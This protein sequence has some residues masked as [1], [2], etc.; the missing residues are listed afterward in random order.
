MNAHLPKLKPNPKM[1][2]NLLKSK[3]KA[4]VTKPLNLFSQSQKIDGGVKLNHGE[5]FIFDIPNLA[6]ELPVVARSHRLKM[7]VN[8]LKLK[9]K[10]KLQ[11]YSALI[12]QTN[13]KCFL[14]FEKI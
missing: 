13:A 3:P 14:R 10:P 11:N 12:Q 1:A 9:F 2:A 6:V 5:I 7:V 4:E 8:S